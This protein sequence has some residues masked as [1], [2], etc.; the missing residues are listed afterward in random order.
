MKDAEAEI[1]ARAAP[2]GDRSSSR[3]RWTPR[4]SPRSS[5]GGPGIPGHADARE[6]DGAAHQA[7]SRSSR[8]R[9][10]GQDEAVHAV[11]ERRAPLARRPAGSQSPD[12]LLHLPRPHRRREDGD[13]ARA[14]RVPVRRR[15]G[16]GAHRHVG[17]HGE[18]RRRAARSARRR[19]TSATRRAAS[20]P[21]RCVAARTRWCSSTRSRRRTRTSSTSCCR[22]STTAASPTAQG[23][24]V[25]FRNTVII[26]TS[27]IGGDVHSRARGAATGRWSRR[28]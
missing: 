20:S 12:R 19:A 3:R 11:A 4:T 10:I 16:D 21:R 14:R 26:M 7:R 18:A 13:R 15:A 22:F 1:K 24:T 2:G 27:N 25:D 6:R 17:V 23:R 9:V 28:R 8:A 5:R